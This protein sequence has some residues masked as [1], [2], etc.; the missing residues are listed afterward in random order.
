[1]G[2]ANLEMATIESRGRGNRAAD[3]GLKYELP[4]KGMRKTNRITRLEAVL[5][6]A[7][8]DIGRASRGL[9]FA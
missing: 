8:D 6:A 3:H 7:G 9:Y 5:P 4:E 1:M 2:V